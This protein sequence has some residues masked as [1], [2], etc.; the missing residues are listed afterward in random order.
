[1]S[2]SP[3]AHRHCDPDRYRDCEI[4][5]NGWGK[6]WNLTIFANSIQRNPQFLLNTKPETHFLN[7][8]RI[9]LLIN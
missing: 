3:F 8:F 4:Q 2:P 6:W 7:L 1:M 9:Y 5:G